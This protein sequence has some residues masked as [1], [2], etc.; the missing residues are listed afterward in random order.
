MPLQTGSV[1]KFL[2][3]VE[4]VNLLMRAFLSWVFVLN[5]N[6]Y[7]ENIVNLSGLFLK[8]V[9]SSTNDPAQLWLFI[10]SQ[11]SKPWC[12]GDLWYLASKLPVMHPTILHGIFLHRDRTSKY[13]FFLFFWMCLSRW[14]ANCCYQKK[15]INTGFSQFLFSSKRNWISLQQNFRGWSNGTRRTLSLA[16]GSI[17]G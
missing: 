8:S 15:W 3:H 16:G 4:K 2:L 6:L 9:L 14:L 11:K 10:N 5:Q 7:T 1:S 13:Q 12:P 17:V